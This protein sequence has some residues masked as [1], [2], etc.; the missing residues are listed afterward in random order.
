MNKSF[1]I[2]NS[3]SNFLKTFIIH[4]NSN[5]YNQNSIVTTWM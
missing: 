2:S 5:H 4:A 3:K 1:G